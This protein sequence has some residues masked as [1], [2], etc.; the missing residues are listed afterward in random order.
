MANK[1][2]NDPAYW[3]PQPVKNVKQFKYEEE[4]MKHS[5]RLYDVDGKQ[6]LTLPLP[7]IPWKFISIIGG[8]LLLG[9]MLASVISSCECGPF[10]ESGGYVVLKHSTVT[11][12]LLVR[13]EIITDQGEPNKLELVRKNGSSFVVYTTE[14][15]AVRKN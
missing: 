9:T 15:N 12:T 8:G 6:K 4:P 10:I 14:V 11:D 3:K 7:K 5:K 13:R 2:Y 1:F